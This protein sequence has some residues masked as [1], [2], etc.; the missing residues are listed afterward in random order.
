MS[1]ALLLGVAMSVDGVRAADE[2]HS[3]SDRMVTIYDQG[4]EQT[5]VTKARTV[6]DALKQADIAIQPSDVTEPG[7]NT[8]FVAKS[9]QI[10]VYRARPV[11]VVDGQKRAKVFTA[12]QSPRQI[13]AATGGTLYDEDVTATGRVENVLEGEGAGLQLVIDRA[14]P[15]TFMLYGK[16]IDARTQATTIKEMLAEKN[17]KL[18]PKDGIS[19][20]LTT[21]IVAGMTVEVWRDGVQTLTLEEDVAMPIRQVKDADKLLGYKQVQTPGKV[22]KKQVTYEVNL[23]NGKEVSRKEIQ[24]VVTLQP[25]EQV[26]VIGAKL[27]TPINPTEAQAL[28]HQMMLSFGF[29]EDQWPCLYNLWMKE[30]GWRVNAGNPTSGAYG[31]PQSLP[32]SKMAT[33]GD[34]YLTNASVQITWG[35]NYIK[36]RYQTPCGAWSAFQRQNWY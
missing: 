27:P 36:N 12:E 3:P 1:L 13:V 25:V 30:S 20:A 33:Y 19:S 24:V 5:I 35:L 26:E 14:T 6:R 17:V 29:G 10:N 28:G 2:Q 16:K 18:G 15:F 32:A 23:Q 8:A 9:Y 11:I 31:I 4:Q 7:L 34:D 21:G 22:G